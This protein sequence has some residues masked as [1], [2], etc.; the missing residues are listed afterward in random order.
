MSK[1]HGHNSDGGVSGHLG[2]VKGCFGNGVGVVPNWFHVGKA[3]PSFLL[4][5]GGDVMS[6]GCGAGLSSG[7]VVGVVV[8]GVAGLVVTN[9]CS[10]GDSAIWGTIGSV[11]RSVSLPTDL[12]PVLS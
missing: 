4:T 11:L 1:T 9:F 7:F 12:L 2:G 3:Q 6:A 10:Y 8:S 5:E